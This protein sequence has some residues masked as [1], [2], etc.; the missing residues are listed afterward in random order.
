MHIIRTRVIRARASA[1]LRPAALAIT[2]ASA[3]LT[4][5]ACAPGAN[6]GSAA[7]SQATATTRISASPTT[8]SILVSTPDVPLFSAL[9][10]AFHASHRNV[11]VKVTSD[12]FNTLVTNPPHILSGSNVPD[13]IRIASFGS[14]RTPCSGM[15]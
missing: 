11:T 6:L 10:Q 12:D 1:R 8:L 15:Q 4:A 3:A 13:I 5:A 14:H 7:P 2:I 9:G